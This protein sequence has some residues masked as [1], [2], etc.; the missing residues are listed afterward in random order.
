MSRYFSVNVIFRVSLCT[1]DVILYTCVTTMWKRLLR[2]YW[3]SLSVVLRRCVYMT[4]QANVA[5]I[6]SFSGS[7]QVLSKENIF[8][9]R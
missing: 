5:E 6:R 8:W 3:E 4:L 7:K 9:E 2:T 1:K